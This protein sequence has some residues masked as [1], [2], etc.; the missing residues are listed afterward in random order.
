MIAAVLRIEYPRVEVGRYRF[1]LMFRYEVGE[2]LFPANVRRAV[3]GGEKPVPAAD[4]H[5]RHA[6]HRACWREIE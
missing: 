5:Q 3:V 6:D 4:V 1:M 2:T